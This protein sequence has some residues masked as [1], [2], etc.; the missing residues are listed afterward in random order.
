MEDQNIYTVEQRRTIR[1]YFLD[2]TYPQPHG[3]IISL[4]LLA[5]LTKY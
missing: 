4:Q 5:A 2:P 3:E 1:D